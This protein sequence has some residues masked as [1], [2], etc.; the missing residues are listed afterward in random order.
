M[1]QH[2]ATDDILDLLLQET[3]RDG[4]K[5][6][7]DD[8]RSLIILGTTSIE[9]LLDRLHDSQNRQ[10]RNRIIQV[11]V[12]IGK[13]AMQSILERVH[14]QGPWYYIRNLI[15]LIGRIGE[16]SHVKMLVP[17]IVHKDLRV[18]KEAVFAIGNLGGKIAGE[19][20]AGQLPLV[21]DDI[22]SL[23]ISVL[24]TMKYRDAGPEL[25]NILESKAAD[26]GKKA[27]ND[28]MIKSCEALAKMGY[29]EAVPALEKIAQAKGFLSIK[30]YDPAV[31][32]AA[33]D[34]L[35]K[36]K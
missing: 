24:G 1:L 19:T 11:M 32:A 27:K 17:M 31:R 5:K 13:P 26:A 21:N 12:K 22:K 4:T 8:L 2:L 3:P 9:R 16:P 18:Q 33:M 34:A 30:S 15:L 36:L 29:K 6:R 20:L 25:V 23:I 10:E 35:A 7:P 28:I 14:Q